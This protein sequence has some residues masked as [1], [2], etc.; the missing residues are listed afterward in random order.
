MRRGLLNDRSKLP[1]GDPPAANR[2][3]R[4][5]SA[6][7]AALHQALA[8]AALPFPAIPACLREPL[9]RPAWGG[10]HQ[11]ARPWRH[12]C[13]HGTFAAGHVDKGG[14]LPGA[15]PRSAAVRRG[16]SA[17]RVPHR[18]RTGRHVAATRHDRRRCDRSAEERRPGPTTC[19]RPGQRV[20]VCAT[21]RPF[22]RSA[23]SE[24]RVEVEVV[25]P[26]TVDPREAERGA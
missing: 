22:S 15:C 23:V 8:W 24:R 6:P 3:P 9:L 26:G 17:T 14:H 25:D 13:A 18:A 4:R 19:V 2:Q 16:K 10:S 21:S 20:G 5:A 12:R 1:P 11:T 7:L